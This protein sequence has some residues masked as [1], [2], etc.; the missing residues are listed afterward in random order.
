MK[1]KKIVGV[2]A[3]EQEAIRA[4]EEL[5]SLGY[6]SDEISVVGRNKEEMKTITDETGSKAPEGVATGAATGGMLG[7]LT[8]FLAGIGALAAP[9]VGPILAAGPI[10]G[11]LTGAAVG[12][13]AGGLVGGL[14]GLGIPEDE[15]K[16]YNSYVEE[17]KLL[18]MVEADDAHR[19]R[20]YD[21]FRNHGTLNSDLY[22]YDTNKDSDILSDKAAAGEV[23]VGERDK[24]RLHEERLD[25][26]KE[27]VKTGEVQV[28][29]EVIKDNKTINVPVQR[30]EVVIERNALDE[31]AADG[32]VIGKK[33]NHPHPGK[34]GAGEREEDEC[35]HRRSI[36]RQTD[37]AG[38]RA[39]K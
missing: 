38:Q 23:N 33:R 15:A 32:E 11:A 20:V 3:S 6:T 7:G 29:K 26:E 21:I 12:A 36:R 37:G 13:G 25:V 18:V 5:K 31:R 10:A 8:G 1:K 22:S 35:R 9:V 34:R 17:D 14:I 24:L 19:S 4:I 16:R 30:E 27:R 2:F 28:H 39:G